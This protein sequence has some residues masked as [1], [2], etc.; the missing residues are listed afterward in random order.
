MTLH[1]SVLNS[2]CRFTAQWLK[3]LLWF[4]TLCLSYTTSN[5]FIA[6]PGFTTALLALFVR[7]FTNILNGTRITQLVPALRLLHSLN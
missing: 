4:F 3:V 5:D 7:L 6:S 2:T 1:L